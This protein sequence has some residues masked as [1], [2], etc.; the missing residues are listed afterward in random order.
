MFFIIHVRPGHPAC[1]FSCGSHHRPPAASLFPSAPG[2]P[3]KPRS[4]PAEADVHEGSDSEEQQF[5]MEYGPMDNS[6]RPNEAKIEDYEW[7]DL[8]GSKVITRELHYPK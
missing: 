4:W 7:R 8:P 6:W 1:P 5:Q 3:P 2:H